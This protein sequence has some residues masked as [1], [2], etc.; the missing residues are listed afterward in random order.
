MA[1]RNMLK[2]EYDIIKKATNEV[3]GYVSSKNPNNMP[4]GSILSDDE[5][6]DIV[7]T[8]TDLL[9]K[10]NKDLIK[11]GS[12]LT[13]TFDEEGKPKVLRIDL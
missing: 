3:V 7:N 11:Y 9:V 8:C 2:E 10:Y 1:T 4:I 12:K 13:F 6:Y 5:K